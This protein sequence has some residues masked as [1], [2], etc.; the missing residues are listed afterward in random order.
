MMCQSMW[1]RVGSQFP[2]SQRS[3]TKSSFPKRKSACIG[4]S[5]NPL[6][7][8]PI[9]HL[10]LDLPYIIHIPKI[11]IPYIENIVIVKG[12]DNCGYW[13]IARHM[14][15]DEQNH[16]LVRSVLVHE[17]KTIKIDY[18]SIFGSEERFKYIIN[19]LHPPINSGEIAYL[20]K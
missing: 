13:V 18:Y 9:I 19:G 7:S 16:A 8:M 12:G 17:L 5:L 14:G 6:V 3:Q 15:M 10:D 2:D 11:M 4:N 20:Y 1:K